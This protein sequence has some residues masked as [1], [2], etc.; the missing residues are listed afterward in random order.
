MPSNN[1]NVS[2]QEDGVVVVSLVGFTG[3][4]IFKPG[5]EITANPSTDNDVAEQPANVDAEEPVEDNSVASDSTNLLEEDSDATEDLTLDR[6]PNCGQHTY[7]KRFHCCSTI[8]S[9]SL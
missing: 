1:I 3:S 6:I 8:A 4:I 5:T 7:T 9:K 2:I